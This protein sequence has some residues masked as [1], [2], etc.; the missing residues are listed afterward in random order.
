MPLEKLT[1]FVDDI[2]EQEDSIPPDSDT[3]SLSREWFSIHTYDP[4]RP[5]LSKS[6]IRKLIKLTSQITRPQKRMRLARDTPRKSGG[7]GSLSE[8]E[9]P[10][11]SRLLKILERSVKGGEDIDPFGSASAEKRKT[12][13]MKSP[14][15][16]DAKGAKKKAPKSKGKGKDGETTNG[17][18]EHDAMEVEEAGDA[19]TDQDF[20]K[21]E[22]L[23]EIANESVLAADC[24]VALLAADKLPKQVCIHNVP[25]KKYLT[26]VSSFTP[27]NLSQPASPQSKTNSQKSSTHSSKP[28]AT[29]TVKRHPSSFTLP[30]P[31]ITLR[32]STAAKSGRRSKLSQPFFLVLTHSLVL[33]LPCRILLSYRRCILRLGRSSLWSRER[34]GRIRR[35]M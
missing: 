5:H 4:G 17:A 11:L 7:V 21:L 34:R 27:K 16:A 25:P 20:Q 9:T 31:T 29:F 12:S 33:K 15:K 14:T 2:F 3:S 1:A 23:L 35:T 28:L 18:P 30:N 8:M 24:C 10:M 26:S 22:K 32:N 19:L 13:P 6:T